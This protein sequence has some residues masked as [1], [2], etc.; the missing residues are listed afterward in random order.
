[1]RRQI[2]VSL[3]LAVYHWRIIHWCRFERN[4]LTIEICAEEPS[5]KP[6]F[7]FANASKALFRFA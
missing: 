2:A 5:Q 3:P 7:P 6:S 1:V 4:P